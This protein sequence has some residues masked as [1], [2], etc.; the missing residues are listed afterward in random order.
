[1]SVQAEPARLQAALEWLFQICPKTLEPPDLH[2]EVAGIRPEQV[3]EAIPA[4]VRAALPSKDADSTPVMIK[5]PAGELAAVGWFDDLLFCA[6]LNSDGT[7]ARLVCGMKDGGQNIIPSVLNPILREVFLRRRQLLIHSAA[8]KCPNGLG[9]QFVALSCGGKTTTS[10]SLVRLGAKLISDDLVVVSLAG[11]KP[12]AYGL[13]KPLNLREP[14]LGFFEELQSSEP[15]MRP[16]S[17]RASV[18]PQSV[19]GAACLDA[20]CPVNVLYFLNLTDTGPSIS[21]MSFGEAMQTL[22]YTHAFCSMQPTEGDSIVG[23]S[24]LLS[25][26]PFYKLNTGN[27]PGYLGKWLLENCHKHAQ[28]QAVRSE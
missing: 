20:S 15:L 1:M 24:D 22:L 27:N 19:Y 5:G 21:P 7:M 10:L 25:L 11:N 18:N 9:L 12:M 8:V 2:L 23:L 3:I 6:W 14:T 13:P 16:S 4:W 26:V 17:G 28:T